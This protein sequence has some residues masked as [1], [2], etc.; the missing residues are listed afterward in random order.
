MLN[1]LVQNFLASLQSK[2][3]A[4]LSEPNLEKLCEQLECKFKNLDLLRQALKHRSYLT[5]TNENRIESNERLELL[6]DAVLGLVVTQ[7]LYETYPREEEGVLTTYRSLLVNR[8]MLSRVGREIG[9]GDFVLLNDAE[10]RSGGRQRDSILSDLVEAVIGAIYLD[11]GLEVAARF[12]HDNITIHLSDIVSNGI[13]KN[14]K[15]LLQEHCQAIGLKGPI[16]RIEEERGPDHDKTF[17][18]SVAVGDKKIGWG[19]GHSK[20]SAEQL[21]AK[22]ALVHL[23]II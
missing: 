17:T 10:E 8:K 9:L 21:A 5:L 6:G 13:I 14:Y 11:G 20:K 23:K 22:E 1:R 12:I 16:Y 15:S 7:Y 4:E 2:K 18:V 3:R 19:K